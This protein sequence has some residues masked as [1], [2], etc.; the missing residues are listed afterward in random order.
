[1]DGSVGERV[2]TV[3]KVRHRPFRAGEALLSDPKVVGRVP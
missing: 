2:E 1:V 3:Q